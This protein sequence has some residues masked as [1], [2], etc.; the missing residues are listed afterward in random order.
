M[1]CWVCP[2]LMSVQMGHS[3]PSSPQALISSGTPLL[4]MLFPPCSHGVHCMP[5]AWSTGAVMLFPHFSCGCAVGD[6]LYFPKDAIA[7]QTHGVPASVVFVTG[8]GIFVFEAASV[9]ERDQW[10]E[11]TKACLDGLLPQLHANA[12]KKQQ[13]TRRLKDIEDRKASRD[14]R[15]AEYAKAGMSNTARIM[16]QGTGR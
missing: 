16:S 5:C 15:R 6:D 9:A 10:V 8:K 11:S 2:P 7:Q 3:N 4:G 13:E 14:V 12:Q 1:G